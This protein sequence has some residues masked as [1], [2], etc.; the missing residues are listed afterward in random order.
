MLFRSQAGNENQAEEITFFTDSVLPRIYS[1][2]PTRGF[3]DGN[4]M[5]Q[6]VE[7]NPVSLT[8]NY[9]NSGIGYNAEPL[10]LEIGRASCRERV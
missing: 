1:T 10:D 6:F 7:Q 8:L 9:G 2:Q 3:A 5:V 4:F